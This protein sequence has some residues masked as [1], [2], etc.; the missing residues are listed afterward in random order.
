M[1]GRTQT[2]PQT[3]AQPPVLPQHQSQALQQ[4]LPYPLRGH[5]Y[6][7]LANFHIRRTDRFASWILNSQRDILE[8]PPERFL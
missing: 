3:P 5:R 4:P 8:R 2:S 7:D 6:W 1:N